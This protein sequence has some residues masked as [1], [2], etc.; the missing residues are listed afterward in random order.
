MAGKL[1]GQNSGTFGG[2]VVPV[3]EDQILAQQLAAAAVDGELIVGQVLIADLDSQ[4]SREAF[5]VLKKERFGK[6][7][8]H[9]ILYAR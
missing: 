3:D 5:Q 9:R 2:G 1:A 8:L 6:L 7:V 4:L